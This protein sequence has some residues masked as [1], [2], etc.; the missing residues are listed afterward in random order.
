MKKLILLLLLLISGSAAAECIS[1]TTGL[2]IPNQPTAPVIASVSNGK[3]Q[4]WGV[5]LADIVYESLIYESGTTRFA[6]LFHDA[7]VKGTHVETGPVRS[8]R[9][10][11]AQLMKEWQAGLIAN[12]SSR[13][14]QAVAPGLKDNGGWFLNT[15]EGRGRQCSSRVQ[16]K[17]APDNM[18]VS[19][20]AV[21]MALPA[22][23]FEAEG[24]SFGTMAE[25]LPQTGTIRLHW[26]EKGKDSVFFYIDGGYVREGWEGSFANVIVQWV[27]Y[28]CMGRADRHMLPVPGSGEAV[29]F[30]GG[31]MM[32]GRWEKKEEDGKTFFYDENDEEIKI[33][34]GRTFIAHLPVKSGRLAYQ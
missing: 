27:D 17:K 9:E 10:F 15:Y 26:G 34:T 12:G 30:T 23:T 25:P 7:L 13:G 5:E 6:F 14:N 24:F 28:A 29:V 18:N 2:P 31:R 33:C 11:H 8:P 19:I 20:S 32:Q 21:H 1:P 22:N 4:P 16:G 3:V